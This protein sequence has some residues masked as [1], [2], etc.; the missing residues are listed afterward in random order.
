M[1]QRLVIILFFVVCILAVSLWA[2]GTQLRASRQNVA[3]LKANQQTLCQTAAAYRTRDSLTA[4]N[5][6]RLALTV[7]ELRDC[8]ADLLERLRKMKIRARE[9]QSAVQMASTS[10]YTF[11][12]DTVYVHDTIGHAPQPSF[13][14]RDPWITF[15][16]SA[17][18][19]DIVTRDSI[20]VVNHCRTRRFLF[21]RRKQYT[22]RTD[23]L[24]YNPHSTITQFTSLKVED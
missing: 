14:Y 9:L 1:R 10:G 4:Y 16:L 19:A 5:T 7:D 18:Q 15:H 17:G 8:N 24:N 6:R 12:V 21:W 3:R 13:V 2:V 11:R 20:V 22:G 23:I